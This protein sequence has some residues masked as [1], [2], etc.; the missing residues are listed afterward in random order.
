MA[1]R[2]VIAIGGSAG[3]FEALKQIVRSF[4]ADFPAAVFVV[5]HLSPRTR[6]YL[7]DILQRSTKM[8]VAQA[9]ENAPLRNG[10]IYVNPPDRHLIVSRDHIHLSRGPKE[11]LQRP[12]I[13]VAFRSAATA[14]G[15]CSTTARRGSGRLGGAAG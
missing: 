8:L 1:N 13:N 14:Y 4:P 15:T 7:P 3:S 5:V 12:S 11:G 9:S 2:D 6:S 10:T